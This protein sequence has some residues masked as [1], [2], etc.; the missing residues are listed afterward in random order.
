MYCSITGVAPSPEISTATRSPALN[1]RSGST[2]SSMSCAISAALAVARTSMPG[3]PWC[4]MP[5]S[6][7]P[8][9]MWKLAL[10][11]AGITQ[12]DRPTPMLRVFA[13]AFC[14]AAITSS[15][16]APSAALAA[17]TF[18][19]KISP[20]TPRRRAS[21]PFAAEGTSSLATTVLT[22]MPSRSAIWRAMP[23]FMLSP[24]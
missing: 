6:I 12:A 17:P 7:V 10:P 19:M 3:S 5:T 22:T 11:T 8:G 4:P 15:R 13:M 24:A 20:A 14:A 1:G 9:S 16:E 23:T 21:S 2:T 18:H